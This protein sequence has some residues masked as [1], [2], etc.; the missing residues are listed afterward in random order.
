MS[1]RGSKLPAL[2]RL[3]RTTSSSSGAVCWCSGSRQSVADNDDAGADSSSGCGPSS[4]QFCRL[5]L[6]LRCTSRRLLLVLE[7]RK[8]K[9]SRQ[10]DHRGSAAGRTRGGG[11]SP[12]RGC[13]RG[14]SQQPGGLS[15]GT[16]ALAAPPVRRTASPRSS[17][18]YSKSWPRK[19]KFGEMLGRLDLTYR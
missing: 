6:R 9:L 16:G 12:S 15:T 14:S 18:S 13:C 4:G 10:S 17:R 5:Q 8:S 1:L 19:L 2:C 3:R 7:P 11:R